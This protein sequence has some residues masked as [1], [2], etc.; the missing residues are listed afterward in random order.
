MDVKFFFELDIDSVIGLKGVEDLR[1]ELES[2]TGRKSIP[3][4]HKSRG[5]DYWYSMVEQ[6]DYVAIGG[7]VTK[8]IK[9]QEYAV[10]NKLLKIAKEHNTKVHGLGFTNTSVLNKYRFYSVDSTTWLCGNRYGGLYKF[11]GNKINFIAKPA[12]KRLIT[13]KTSIHNFNEWVKFQR[14]AKN[15]L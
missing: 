3:V 10:F 9:R 12:N 11:T 1:D 13:K 15:N 5:L 4:W 6:Y 7:I 14:Y 8:E 2:L